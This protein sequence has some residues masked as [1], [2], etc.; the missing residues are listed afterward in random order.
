MKFAAIPFLHLLYL[1]ATYRLEVN[2]WCA[3]VKEKL[4]ARHLSKLRSKLLNNCPY[5]NGHGRWSYAVSIFMIS[6]GSLTI[7]WSRDILIIEKVNFQIESHSSNQQSTGP[8][9]EM[10]DMTTEDGS[11]TEGNCNRVKAH[12]GGFGA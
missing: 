10:G 1:G 9:R 8:R 12:F 6:A 2:L 7:T 3:R 5:H 11:E 4:E